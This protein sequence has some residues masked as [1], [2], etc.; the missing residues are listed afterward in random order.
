MENFE[1]DEIL[2]KRKPAQCFPEIT[3]VSYENLMNQFYKNSK[4][5]SVSNKSVNIQPSYFLNT[6]V[7]TRENTMKTLS[8]TGST[9]P[10]SNNLF[11]FQ[12]NNH[13]N[14]ND[15]SV[16]KNNDQSSFFELS[17]ENEAFGENCA[18]QT[19]N[20][21][22]NIKSFLSRMHSYSNSMEDEN[23]SINMKDSM[24]SQCN[25]PSYQ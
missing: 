5:G 13:L 7:N 21:N 3:K 18:E 10:H 24:F 23:I 16:N 22:M 11:D 12:N 17:L 25:Q 19:E 8:S 1:I 6:V 2:K 15:E 4:F 14:F 20:L 9:L